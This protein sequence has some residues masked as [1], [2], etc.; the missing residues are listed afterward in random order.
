MLA[1]SYRGSGGC[2]P[3]FRAQ[4]RDLPC[5]PTSRSCT[6]APAARYPPVDGST[7]PVTHSLTPLSR[8]DAPREPVEEATDTPVTPE[9]VLTS[10]VT[11]VELALDET[12]FDLVQLGPYQILGRLGAGG[13]GVVYEAVQTHPI[14]R[15]VAVKLMNT[16]VLSTQARARFAAER[17][18]MARL[19]HVNIAHIFEAGTT[20]DGRAYFVME[21]VPG[22]T[23]KKYCD[24]QELSIAERL[25]LFLDVCAGV[26]H[27]HRK[28]V[29]HRDLKPSNILVAEDDDGRRLVKV[30]DFGLA[31]AL[32]QPLTEYGTMTGS[33]II[34]TPAYMSPEALSVGP[35]ADA[36]TDTRT[37]V[38]SLGVVLYEL[39][40]GV[41]PFQ[42]K[43]SDLASALRYMEAEAPLP[44]R[45]FSG[46]QEAQRAAIAA[47]RSA[48]GVELLRQLRGELGW[49]VRKA[50]AKDMDRRYQS[51]AELA[52]DL[53]RYLAGKP[54]QAGPQTWRYLA[55]KLIRRHRLVF[56]TAAITVLALIVAVVGTTTSMMR[57]RAAEEMARQAEESARRDALAAKQVADFMVELFETSDPYRQSGQTST[58]REILQRGAERIA[59]RLETQPMVRAHMQATLGRVF[60]EL[61]LFQDAEPLIGQALALRTEHLGAAHPDT[62]QSE[63]DRANLLSHT[64]RY[65]EA[66][67]AAE[68]ALQRQ[69]RHHGTLSYALVP[70]LLVLAEA[71][72][73]HGDYPSAERALQ[74]ARPLSQAHAGEESVEMGDI[75]ESLGQVYRFQ[76]HIR[77]AEAL[78]RR[79]LD[80][81]EA[82]FGPDH[83]RLLRAL[84]GLAISAADR[85]SQYPVYYGRALRIAET[86]LGENHPQV[87]RLLNNLGFT[88]LRAGRFE[89]ARARLQRALDLEAAADDQQTMATAALMTNLAHAYWRLQR[90][91]EAEPLFLRAIA[92][93]ARILAPEHPHHATS[94]WGLANVYRDRGRIQ[95]AE[96]LYQEA[97]TLRE[98]VLAPGDPELDDALREYAVLLRLQDRVPEA[99]ALEARMSPGALAGSPKAQ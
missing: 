21:Y 11:N 78:F 86:A 23:I 87:R 70:G 49:V 37:D 93:R 96:A 84:S 20:A 2:Q 58:V 75:L 4:A 69:E 46:L 24:R 7:P 3:G 34:G 25:R 66:I 40:V 47:R 39:L 42:Q 48:D 28:Q 30:I 88:L 53:E 85:A 52:D 98:R 45:R 64:G 51:P 14:R 44:S 36:D 43:T 17:Q 89:E 13:M 83:P 67:A 50:M 92:I 57:A 19:D 81:Q 31:K 54:V 12:G 38:Y 16:S 62:T 71:Y 79:A 74:R 68:S 9:T 95:E 35:H 15:T 26:Q 27:A 18:A 61:G 8:P 77:E 94:K 32:D 80:I 97:L 72:R 55:G 60:F 41:L 1:S 6:S 65:Q 5:F 56:A 10:P 91:D 90:L 59:G 99:E 73:N 33:R 63:L 22:E 82:H 76:G 29:M